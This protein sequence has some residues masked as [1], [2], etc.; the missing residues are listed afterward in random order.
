MKKTKSVTYAVLV[1]DMLNDFV[2]G[3]LK[4]TRA[5]KIIPK[6]KSLLEASRV[7]DIPIFYCNDAHLSSDDYEFKLWGP[8]A[9]KGTKGAR[10]IDDLTPSNCDNIVPKR[11]YSAFYNTRLDG[12]LKKKFGNKGPDVLIITG[13]HTNICAKHTAFDAFVRGYDIVIPEDGVTAFQENEH[14][15]ALDYMKTN[16][17]AKIIKTSKLINLISN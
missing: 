3:K 12:L 16:Y 1:V 5:K 11:T 2:Y 9:L 8:H 7:K 6:I 14:S 4:C 15:T 17:G 13:I 10:V